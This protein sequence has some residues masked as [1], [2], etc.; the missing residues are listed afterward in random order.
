[1]AEQKLRTNWQSLSDYTRDLLITL[2][3]DVEGYVRCSLDLQQRGSRL[4]Q[5]TD[6][7][8]DFDAG[9]DDV[10]FVAGIV[11]DLG[12]TVP[13]FDDDFLPNVYDLLVEQVK[14]QQPSKDASGLR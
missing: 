1:M 3:G 9:M 11:E 8:V 10:N 14:Q 6:A 4:L 12:L 13:K 5:L 7:I 2:H